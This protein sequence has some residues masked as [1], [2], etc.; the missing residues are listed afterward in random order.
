MSIELVVTLFSV[1]GML[2]G[3]GVAWGI[4]KSRTSSLGA[5]HQRLKADF[6]THKDNKEIH[7]DPVRDKRSTEDYRESVNA[8]FGEIK[9]MIGKLDARCESRGHV[10]TGHF[11]SLETKIAA[12]TG[13][14]NGGD[15]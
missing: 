10:C 9:Q 11:V 14:A 6:I 7:I 12:A 2:L 8:N 15:Q 5:S 3:A 13:R 4:L 1:A